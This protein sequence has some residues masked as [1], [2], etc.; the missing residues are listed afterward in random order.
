M[1]IHL[2]DIRIGFFLQVND[3][4]DERNTVKELINSTRPRVFRVVMK[5]PIS[6]ISTYLAICVSVLNTQLNVDRNEEVSLCFSL[7]GLSR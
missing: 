5:L 4:G 7:H 1:Y 3:E 2:K 6:I